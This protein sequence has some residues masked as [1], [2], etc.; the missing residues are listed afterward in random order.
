[1]KL[2]VL[3]NERSSGFRAF[4]GARTTMPGFIKTEMEDR[5]AIVTVNRPD[6][7][8]ALNST[9]LR[10]LSMAIEHLSMAADVG[11]IILTGAGDRAFVA[12]ADIKEMANLSGLEMQRFSE[13]GRRLGDTM[14]SCNKPIIAAIN[15]VALGRGCDRSSE[16]VP[17][18]GGGHAALRRVGLRDGGVR[19]RGL[20]PRQGGRDARLHRETEAGVDGRLI[21][22]IRTPLASRSRPAPGLPQ[23]RSSGTRACRRVHSGCGR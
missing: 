8:N 7:L 16:G 9:V 4:L 15:G 3:S 5:L 22:T 21:S 1:M 23:T 18:G 12:G 14:A 19:D 13:M 11:A 6:A 10:E 2:T 20:D 17:P